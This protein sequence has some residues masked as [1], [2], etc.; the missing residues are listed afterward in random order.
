MLSFL[1][2]HL[3]HN[4]KRA[5]IRKNAA[6]GTGGTRDGQAVR[7]ARY[8]VRGTAAACCGRVAGVSRRCCGLRVC[9][10]GV[11][12]VLLSCL[13]RF[14]ALRVAGVSCRSV[15]G[16]LRFVAGYLLRFVA[17]CGLLRFVLLRVALCVA[18]CCV[19]RFVA[20]GGYTLLMIEFILFSVLGLVQGVRR[21]LFWVSR[22][23]RACLRD[24][25]RRKGDE[26]AH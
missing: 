26:G 2:V 14:V 10:W 9:C 17:C 3:C 23:I 13:L 21:G 20:G 25:M 19:L 1:M 11:A 6:C 18:V 16:L 7:G 15:S 4:G 22:R 8:G 24:R 5:K 12:G